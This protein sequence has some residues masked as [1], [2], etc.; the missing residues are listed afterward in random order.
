M[1]KL[2]YE[3]NKACVLSAAESRSENVLVYYIEVPSP[4]VA[5]ATVDLA[6]LLFLCNC[7]VLLQMCTCGV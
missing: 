5:V 3:L 6:I 4:P 1:R 7:K 2:S